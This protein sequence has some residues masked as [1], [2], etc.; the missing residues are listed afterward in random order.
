MNKILKSELL[1]QGKIITV[2][3]QLVLLPNDQKAIREIVHHQT[4]VGILAIHKETLL[5]VKQYRAGIE[6]TIL[7]IPAG[8]LEKGET[9]L[10]CARRELQ[11]ET[12]YEAKKMTLLGQFYLSPGYSDEIIYLFL[13]EDLIYNPLVPDDDEDI[14]L[15]SV[16]CSKIDQFILSTSTILDAKSSL[17]LSLYLNIEKIKKR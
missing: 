11:E 2:E 1:Y 9:P 6:D 5:F 16:P 14:T 17:A 3:K 15:V 7:E 10:S 12:G 4:G 13:G 8:L